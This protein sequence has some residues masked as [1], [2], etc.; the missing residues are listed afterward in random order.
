MTKGI[1]VLALLLNRG[2][3]SASDKRPPIGTNLNGLSYYSTELP[4]LDAF[5]TAGAWVSGTKE[6]WS[7]GRRLDLDRRGWVRSLMRGQVALTVLFHDTAKFSGTLARRYVVEYEGTGR[8]EYG[9]LAKLVEH[10]EQRDVIEI[11]PGAGN[12]TLTLTE[13]DPSDHLR[14]IR[15][16]PQASTAKPGE[17]FNPVFLER[18]KGYRALRFM[19]WM[20]GES[21][22]DI[23]ARRWNKRPTLQ[24]AVWTVKG[25]PVETMVALSNRVHADPWFTM[26]HAAD[27]EYVRRFAQIVK[28]SLDPKL[29]VYLE[30]SNEVWNT[31]YP[32]TAYARKQGLAL[33]LSEDPDEAVLRFYAKRAVEMF[34]IWEQ[35]L[36]K[37]RLVRV[38]AF[39]SDI[40]PQY[41]DEV[42]L[43][44]GDAKDHVDA[45]AIGPYFG[46]DLAADAAG[47]ARI[48]KLSLDELMRELE[49]ASL[50]KAK[51]QMLAH[52]AAARKYGLPLIAYE[53]G[54]HLWNMSGQSAPG[55]DALFNAANRDSRMGALY[56]RYLNDWTE[57]GGGP[58]MHLLDCGNFENA[59]NWGALEY[60]TQP[61]AEAPKF[62]ALQRF[63]EGG[64]AP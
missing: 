36:G 43:S 30:Y 17:L 34:S 59:G 61:R 46:T 19:I 44:F 53:G 58:F 16:T 6:N 62:D 37:E 35:V 7:D 47:A 54:Q 56:S 22:E 29:K 20:L 28:K 64:A 3:L 42:A 45:V 23:A 25:A 24:D 1:L 33:G 63:I 9:E 40:D 57:A 51:A 13:T 50:P 48:G 31:E 14:D 8:L 15:I 27:D 10:A 4:F 21:S 38:L 39:Q 52:A 32:Q 11:E 2:G 60:L 18:L 55:L 5:K 41:S 26:P 12:A 49:T